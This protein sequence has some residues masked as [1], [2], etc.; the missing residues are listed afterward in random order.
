MI[1][2]LIAA[3]CTLWM[4]AATADLLPQAA[5]APEAQQP[6]LAADPAD[7]QP[8]SA[9]QAIPVNPADQG[10]AAPQAEEGLAPK[11]SIPLD[12]RKGGDITSCLGDGT[13][14]DKEIAAC[15]EPYSPLHKDH[16]SQHKKK[17]KKVLKKQGEK[18]K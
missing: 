3:M 6:P 8:A 17:T 1:R 9:I 12:K 15:A 11:S 14:T 16:P 2:L 4:V 5:S 18:K 7:N 10:G 13:R